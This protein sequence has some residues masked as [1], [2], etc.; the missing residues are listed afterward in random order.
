MSGAPAY[1]RWPGWLLMAMVV[2]ALLAVGVQ[3]AGA[4]RT[5][6]ERVQSITSRLAC[7]TCNGESVA[8]SRAISAEQIRT[9]VEKLVVEGTLTDDQIVEQVDATYPDELTLLPSTSGFDALVWVL[10]AMAAVGGVASLVAVFLRWQR[11][12]G[13]EGPTDQDR[14]LV[15]AALRGLGDR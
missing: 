10:P 1:K 5:A 12:A 8:D 14:D 2:A 7:P 13:A 6:D 15:D 4:P 9:N 11:R 3:R